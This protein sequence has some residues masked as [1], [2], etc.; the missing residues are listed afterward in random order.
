MLRKYKKM[1]TPDLLNLSLNKVLSRTLVTNLTT[2]LAVLALVTIGGPTLQGFSLAMMW[3]MFVGS[4]STVYIALPVLVY[5]EMRREDFTN[6]QP[7][8]AQVPEYERQ[9][10]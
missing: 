1:N 10:K 6:T 7:G 8:V 4:Y 3:G 2:T 9:L 5:F